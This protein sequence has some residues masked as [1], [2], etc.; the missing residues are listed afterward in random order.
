MDDQYTAQPDPVGVQ[1]VD[2][3]SQVSD[4]E[5]WVKNF[6]A[7][8]KD[9]KRN[10]LWKYKIA[11]KRIKAENNVMS[12]N[13][14]KMS[15]YNVPLAYSVG[16]NFVNSV[17]FKAPECSLTA[18]E[19]V[20]HE[21]IEN[22][23][24]AVN[25]WIKDKKVK[26]TI[27]RC[28][29]DAY[30]GG[31]GMRFIDH[32]YD[33]ME[34]NEQ[35]DEKP[36]LDEQGQP[37]MEP[38]VDEMGEPIMVPVMEPIMNRIVLENA[39]TMQRIRPDM[40]RFPKGFDFDN[41]Q[42]SPWLGFNV[43]MPIEEAK[44]HK[45]WDKSVTEM[46]QGED[47]ENLSD[48]QNE[49]HSDGET[50]QKYVKISYCFKKPKNAMEP[51][52][53]YVFNDKIKTKPLMYEPWDKGTI[54]YPLKP[55]YFN[56]LDDDNSY[57]NG[58]C[59]NMESQLSAVDTWWKKY[60]RHVARSNPKR[61]FDSSA[62]DT[63]EQNNLKSNNDVEWVGVKNKDRRDIRTFITDNNAP[64]LPPAVDKLYEVARTLLDAVGPKSGMTQGTGTADNASG[65]A[66]EAKIIASGDMI[67]V[68]ARID[69]VKD[70]I[71]DIVLDIA[72]IMEKSL[73]KGI[74]VKKEIE[75][76]VMGP[77]GPVM[78]QM[79]GQPQM[80]TV[81]RV[82]EINKDG[83]TGKINADVD[84]ESMQAQNKDVFRKQLI[85]ALG[86]LTKMQPLFQSMGKIINP[87]FWTKRLMETMHIRNIDEGFIDVP[88]M[89]NV[90]PGAV[91]PGMP[92]SPQSMEPSQTPEA[93]IMGGAQQV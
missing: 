58:D 82:E 64:E 50:N 26:K 10:F 1:T 43:L 56:P 16:Q 22:T 19:E 83:F 63:P 66:T 15:H 30:A 51:M 8:E 70:F 67:D 59:W 91:P 32:R 39:I 73:E 6:H 21:K 11:K 52:T 3:Q 7:S 53:L 62:I 54:G 55:I 69:D 12:R 29:W 81:E 42:D 27:R 74:P 49:K 84:V 87:V 13:S 18:R 78:D 85:D 25:D 14:Y 72:G 34:G 80:K 90:P 47:Y 46:L 40:C 31:F 65:T 5:T 4:V 28:I 48:K 68:E 88:P 24:I 77:M 86:L 57:P 20:E 33:D 60:V 92:P 37:Q 2:Q 79:T 41:Y 61:I 44:E 89:T 36:A 71:T 17:Y 23:E 9:M 93:S 38:G 35:I 76:P 75:E 45:E